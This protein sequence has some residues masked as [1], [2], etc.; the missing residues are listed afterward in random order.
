MLCSWSQ[1][2]GHFPWCRICSL[3]FTRMRPGPLIIC[4]LFFFERK[5]KDFNKMKKIRKHTTDRV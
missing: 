1:P 5:Q 2:P 3:Y 4:S